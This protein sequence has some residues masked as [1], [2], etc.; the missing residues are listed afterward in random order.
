MDIDDILASVDRDNYSSPEST[1]LDHQQLTRYWVAERAVSELLPWPAP[2]MD[3]MM[4]RVRKQIE[5]I[6]DLAASSAD[7]STSTTN[8]PTL[9]LKLS[10]LQT[11]LSRTQYLIRSFLRQRLSKLTKYSMHY[12]LLISPPRD[13]QQQQQSTQS[14]TAQ[15]EDSIPDPSTAIDT[16]PLSR[17]EAAFIHA[18]QNLLAEHYG[19]SFMA[20]FPP[21]LRRL[22]DNAGGTS[23]VQAPDTKEIVFVRCLV[24]EVSILIPADEAA[25]FEEEYGTTMHMGE[26]WVV[27]WEGIKKSWERGEVE[28]L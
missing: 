27:R 22:D 10:I 11:D 12:L 2:L 13:S 16:S 28:I 15:P 24:E 23:M 8:N 19:L 1:A 20:S 9:N 14:T 26:V 3:R 21:R 6:E 17:Q 25:G 7:P 18:H 4:E 5:I